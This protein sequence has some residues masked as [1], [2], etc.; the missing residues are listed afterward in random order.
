MLGKGRG[1]RVPPPLL[2]LPLLFHTTFFFFF[3]FFFF[4]LL[5]S[6][7]GAPLLST[8]PVC[9]LPYRREPHLP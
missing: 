2:P 7:D 1:D 9:D 4:F 5:A 6:H 8:S 3:F